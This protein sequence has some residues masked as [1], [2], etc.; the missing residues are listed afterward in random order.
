MKLHRMYLV[1]LLLTTVA[2]TAWSAPLTTY[3]T[4]F[5]VS[6]AAQ[7][8]TV[9]K[10]IRTLLLTRLAGDK[11]ATVTTQDGATLQ[12]SGSYLQSGAMF[13]LDAAVTNSSGTVVT[14]AFSQG[15]SVDDLIPAVTALAKSLTDGIEKGA[16]SVASVPAAAVAPVPVAAVA[17][18][19]VALPDI[20][21][22]TQPPPPPVSAP[23]FF[24]LDG[25]AGSMA[26]GRTLPGGERE[27]FVT[28]SR[29]LR[30]YRLG[31]ELKLMAE[32]L[33]K[34]YEKLLSVDTA[35]LDGDGTPEIY[36][37]MM[38]NDVLKS[39]VWTVDGT[40]LKKIAGPLPYFFR[41][42]ATG[43]GVAKLYAQQMSGSNNFSG[44]V[45]ELIKTG[46]DFG[47]KDNVTLP[48]GGYL[49]NFTVLKGSKGEKNPVIID[50]GGYLK[51]FTPGLDELWKSSEEFGGSEMFFWGAERDP[52]SDDAKRKVSLDPRMVITAAGDLLVPKNTE[53]WF[54]RNKHYYS[55]SSLYSFAW[56]GSVLHEKW[57]TKPTDYYLA[58]FAYDDK[59]HELFMLEVVAKEEGIFDKGASRLVIKKI[60]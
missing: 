26:L 60:E 11:I 59:S 56:N 36:V 23:A 12:V 53:S 49:Y 6:G 16:A 19:P 58:D 14:R 24:K 17:P 52:V 29:T 47:L 9:Q 13:S 35:D 42:V 3:V 45:A 31:T 54:M 34:V 7:P 48:R 27:L 21:K 41:T 15:K 1:L 51:V 25:A 8:E 43:S 57:H 32:I 30:Y 2:A 20:I 46:N 38:A 22:A 50:R 37:T 5:S 40:V 39:Q 18:A 55:G 4:E 44:A 10:T 33:Y 28:G